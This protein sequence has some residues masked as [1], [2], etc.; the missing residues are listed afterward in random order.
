MGRAIIR[1]V[2]GD[3]VRTLHRDGAV[4][5][6]ATPQAPI[7]GTTFARA[8]IAGDP[9]AA[10]AVVPAFASGVVVEVDDAITTREFQRIGVHATTSDA[11][12]YFRLPPI[13]RVAFVRLRVQHAGF[14]DSTPIVPLDYRNAIQRVTVAME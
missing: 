12:G 13:A 7:N 2:V 1:R 9:V 14:T 3:H 10:L 6:A 5:T 11:D 4:C 8:G